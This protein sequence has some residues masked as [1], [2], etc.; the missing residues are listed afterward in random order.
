MFGRYA[1]LTQFRSDPIGSE[2]RCSSAPSPADENL[3]CGQGLDCARIDLCRHL[4]GCLNTDAACLDGC[5]SANPHGADKFEALFDCRMS[6][7]TVDSESRCRNNLYVEFDVPTI[8]PES[9]KSFN[10]WREVPCRTK[11]SV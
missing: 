4:Q 8:P 10:R 9:P 6:A 11:N 3:A 5:K 2:R 7:C 1:Q